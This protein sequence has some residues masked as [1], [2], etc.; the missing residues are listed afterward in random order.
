LN[1]TSD[2]QRKAARWAKDHFQ[3]LKGSDP[4][5]PDSLNDRAADCWRSL[6]AIADLVGGNWPKAARAA[7]LALVSRGD[8]STTVQLLADIRSLF[9]Q[10]Q[11]DKLS[12]EKIVEEL[13]KLDDRSW[14]EWKNGKPISKN[15]LS[16]QLSKFEIVSKTIRIPGKNTIKG[17]EREQFED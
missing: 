9:G 15:Q 1:E 11:T 14:P 12:S 7:A 6:I 3:L 17:Y 13:G 8:S 5:I 4:S 16:R 10:E 2:I